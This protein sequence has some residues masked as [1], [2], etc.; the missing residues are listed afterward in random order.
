VELRELAKIQ[1]QFS[2]EKFPH[3]WHVEGDRDAVL[4]LEYFTNALAGE[5]GE[6][7]NV[8]KKV[9]RA[10][11]YGGKGLTLQEALPKIEEE[12]TDIFIYVLTMASF[13]GIDLEQAYFK[14]LEE[15]RKRF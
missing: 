1:A 6:L 10:T 3:F 4:R 11:V 12:L 5:V 13:L 14:K 9:V 7:A 2:R 8:V 15:N